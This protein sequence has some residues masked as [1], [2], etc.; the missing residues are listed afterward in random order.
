MLE[1][2]QKQKATLRGGG[3]GAVSLV[4]QH[5]RLPTGLQALHPNPESKFG[6]G[7]AEAQGNTGGE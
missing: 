5:A 6:A 1:R 4:L 3:G 7:M 2:S